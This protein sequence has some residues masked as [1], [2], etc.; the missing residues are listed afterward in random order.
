MTRPIRDSF[1]AAAILAPIAYA[2]PATGPLV[3]IARL[4]TVF[5]ATLALLLLV[6]SV[7]TNLQW[8]LTPPPSWAGSYSTA[9]ARGH[10][11]PVVW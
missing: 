6:V 4:L 1:V 11:G 2:I 5:F 3:N 8:R 7:F 9:T 10:A